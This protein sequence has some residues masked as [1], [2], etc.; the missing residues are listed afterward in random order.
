MEE[1]QKI[2][3][4]EDCLLQG[5]RLL[6][7]SKMFSRKLNSAEHVEKLGF[8]S[9]FSEYTLCSSIIRGIAVLCYHSISIIIY[10]DFIY[11]NT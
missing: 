4:V 3:N 7:F 8:H 2:L 5:Q 9:C 11:H 1:G 10:N 6:D